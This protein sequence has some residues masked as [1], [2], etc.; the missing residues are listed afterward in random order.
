MI[1]VRYADDFIVGFHHKSAARRFLDEMRER[2]RE[3][4]STTNCS[5]AA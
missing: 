3:L 4:V 5:Q 1:F 2:Q